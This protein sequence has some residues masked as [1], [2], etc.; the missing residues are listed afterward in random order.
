MCGRVRSESP[1]DR[2]SRIGRRDDRS[3]A[4]GEFAMSEPKGTPDRWRSLEPFLSLLL[5]AQFAAAIAFL[6]HRYLQ[7]RNTTAFPFIGGIGMMALLSAFDLL[8]RLRRSAPAEAWVGVSYV[9]LKVRLWLLIAFYILVAGLFAF[10]CS[11]PHEHMARGMLAFLIL[12]LPA[13]LILVCIF[14]RLKS[15]EA[16][17]AYRTLNGR[18]RGSIWKIK[19]RVTTGGDY[20]DSPDSVRPLRMADVPGIL[21]FL[22]SLLLLGVVV[23]TLVVVG[24]VRGY[25][26]LVHIPF[27][28]A[29]GIAPTVLGWVLLRNLLN[30]FTRAPEPTDQGPLAAPVFTLRSKVGNEL[31]GQYFTLFFLLAWTTVALALGLNSQNL[32]GIAV[33]L[34]APAV[35]YM[36]TSSGA[37]GCIA[38][39][40]RA[41]KR[42]KPPPLSWEDTQ[43]LSRSI[44][45][46]G[47]VFGYLTLISGLFLIHLIGGLNDGVA[48][49]Q[50]SLELQ[51]V[52][53]TIKHTVTVPWAM[54]GWAWLILCTLSTYHR[55]TIH[56]IYEGRLPGLVRLTA[57]IANFF[58]FRFVNPFELLYSPSLRKRIGRRRTRKRPKPRKP[59]GKEADITEGHPS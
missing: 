57:L 34:I 22:A 38:T 3:P 12:L 49:Q 4:Q 44:A 13:P 14:R 7:D 51:G 30:V 29:F 9:V 36:A 55:L 23:I 27:F 8:W 5:L 28:L 52:P 10:Y 18:L 46:S 58:L 31:A 48:F 21:V 54:A 43:R 6:A 53:L 11:L 56:H 26:E 15:L 20:D 37:M 39:Y 45:L 19:K 40:Q 17:E 33:G 16:T 1:L 41:E 35:A 24:C 32:M 50:T 59:S 42:G 47:Y 2:R 25:S